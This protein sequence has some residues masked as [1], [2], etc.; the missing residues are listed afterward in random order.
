M[1]S[2]A[3]SAGGLPGQIQI[4]NATQ[5]LLAGNGYAVKRRGS[6]N[7]EGKGDMETWLLMGHL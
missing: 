3:R 1:L 5:Q 7:I 4:T 2:N 6:I